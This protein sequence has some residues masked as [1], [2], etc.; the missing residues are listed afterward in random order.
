MMRTALVA[1][2]L[3]SAAVGAAAQTGAANWRPLDAN[4]DGCL[5]EA[6][7]RAIFPNGLWHPTV[8]INGD[9][10][11]DS[12]DA[13]ALMLLRS[14]WDRNA[15][16]QVDDDDF[17]PVAPVSLPEPDIAAATSLT[18]RLL[19]QATAKLPPGQEDRLMQEWPTF[20]FLGRPEQAALL[21]E[22]GVLALAEHNLDVAQW[23]FARSA[24]A[25]ITRA[26]ALADLG[27]TLCEQGAYADALTL[28]S[29][30]RQMDPA[31]APTAG[32]IA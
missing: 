21:E 27:Y 3:V 20:Q 32:N 1:T 23:A 12:Q 2:M 6:D 19:V 14:R 11:K 16:M 18:S 31:S 10:Q 15:D 24:Q 7:A 17:A 30:A 5:D 4:A 29:R 9:G 22:A 26:S 25:D 13:F 28:L 8:D